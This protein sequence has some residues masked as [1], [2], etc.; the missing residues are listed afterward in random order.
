[1]NERGDAAYEGMPAGALAVFTA[2]MSAAI[3]WRSEYILWALDEERVRASYKCKQLRQNRRGF[4]LYRDA[5]LP[6]RFVG[7]TSAVAWRPVTSLQ[8][9]SAV[10]RKGRA[11]HVS[12]RSRVRLTSDAALHKQVLKGAIGH[13]PANK[14][15][16]G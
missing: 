14:P 1:M 8:A 13:M 6:K 4:D 11:R 16:V 2:V 5:V 3:R 7:T 10:L 15:I 9:H 12:V